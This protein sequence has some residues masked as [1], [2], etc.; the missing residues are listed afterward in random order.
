MRQ[1]AL[2]LIIFLLSIVIQSCSQN[3]TQPTESLDSNL[4]KPITI[5]SNSIVK[6][7]YK[8]TEFP[9]CFEAAFIDSTF[10]VEITTKDTT[11]YFFQTLELGKIKIESG[12]IIACDPIVNIDSRPFTQV[13]PVGEFSVQLAIAKIPNNNRVAYSRI[14]F[15]NNPVNKWIYATQSGEKQIPIN[16]TTTYCFGVDA[17]QATYIDSIANNEL[18]KLEQPGWV[19]AFSGKKWLSPNFFGC[20]HSFNNHNLAAFNTGWGDGCYGSYIGLDKDG[21][22]CRLITDFGF[23]MW[24]NKK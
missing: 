8:G 7:N 1:L 22:I 18:D 5:I 10:V 13:F 21:N 19:A 15:S 23:V 16:D 20:I 6:S 2:Q 17:G 4:S 3:R 12:K 9:N 24:W 11:T 14:V